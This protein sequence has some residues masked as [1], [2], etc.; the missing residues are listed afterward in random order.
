MDP[1]YASYEALQAL[2][3]ARTQSVRT[4]AAAAGLSERRHH[5]VAQRLVR[6]MRSAVGRAEPGRPVGRSPETM[7]WA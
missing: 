5:P 3:E 1:R 2:H 7:F 6:W 4:S